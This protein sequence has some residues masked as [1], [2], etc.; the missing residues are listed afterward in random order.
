MDETAS[1]LR[2][3]IKTYGSNSYY[4]AHSRK[5]DI[6]ADAIRV[7]GD[8]LVTGGMPVLLKVGDVPTFTAAATKRLTAYAWADSGE[9]VK[10]YIEDS[11][12][13]ALVEG[14]PESIVTEFTEKSLSVKVTNAKGVVI[15][16]S[17]DNLDDEIEASACSFKSSPKRF[18][19][20]LKKKKVNKTWYALRKN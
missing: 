18:T 2:E 10:I 4:Y 14:Q 11:E 6:P 16:F 1:K 17:I 20:T 7:E 13:L 3:S 5:I 19:L 12:W 15:V 9:T 8:G